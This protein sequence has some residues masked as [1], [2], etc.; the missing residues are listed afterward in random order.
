MEY[1]CVTL[2]IILGLKHPTVCGNGKGIGMTFVGMGWK[3]EQQL[4]EL[5]GSGRC[6]YSKGGNG[7]NNMFPC[8]T[9]MET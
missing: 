4:W 9:L 1:C 3:C 8:K 2:V 7:T 5:E 6:S